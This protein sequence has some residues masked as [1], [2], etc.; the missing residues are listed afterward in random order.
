MERA[1]DVAIEM[2]GREGVGP[3]EELVRKLLGA[4]VTAAAARD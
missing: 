3:A 1:R 2:I 4:E